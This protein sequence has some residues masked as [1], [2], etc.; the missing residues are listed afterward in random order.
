MREGGEIRAGPDR[1]GSHDQD[2]SIGLDADGGGLVGSRSE[3]GERHS[4]RAERG[5][6]HAGRERSRTAPIEELVPDESEVASKI[7]P[8]R[9]THTAFASAEALITIFAF[10]AVPKLGLSVP[11]AKSSATAKL[12]V[13]TGPVLPAKMIVPLGTMV[14][15]RAS[16]LAPKSI[17]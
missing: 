14:T 15:P 7:F 6:Q 12:V 1:G 3:G 13:P 8:L 5:V 11:F 10:P 4:S 17:K 2:L 9:S 16:S